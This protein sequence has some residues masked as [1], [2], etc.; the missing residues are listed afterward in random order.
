MVEIEADLCPMILFSVSDYVW[1]NFGVFYPKA[2]VGF[3]ILVA[4]ESASG[5]QQ[6]INSCCGY[7]EQ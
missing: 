1:G 5:Q 3:T 7:Y 2:V 4:R 6:R